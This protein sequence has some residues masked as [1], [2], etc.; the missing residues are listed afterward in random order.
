MFL[1][2]Y[3]RRLIT[4]MSV[5]VPVVSVNRRVRD[6]EVGLPVSNLQ[7]QP[8]KISHFKPIMSPPCSPHFADVQLLLERSGKISNGCCVKLA[9]VKGAVGQKVDR[10][11]SSR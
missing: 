3:A 11:S 6:A 5:H 8:A 9:T 4:G 7:A 2:V 10:W 1:S